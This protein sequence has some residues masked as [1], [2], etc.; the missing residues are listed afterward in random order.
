[1]PADTLDIH[2]SCYASSL[3][4]R[5]GTR[6]P[7]ADALETPQQA[8]DVVCPGGTIKP[9]RRMKYVHPRALALAQTKV[10]QSRWPDQPSLPTRGDWGGIRSARRQ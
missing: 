4:Q 8:Q 5:A 1:M 6:S 3:L 10:H 9:S 7:R 2:D